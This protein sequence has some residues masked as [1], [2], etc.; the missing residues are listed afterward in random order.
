M[1]LY[2]RFPKEIEKE[3]KNLDKL[4][5]NK[6]EEIVNKIPDTLLTNKHKEY[7][8]IFIKE[9]KRLLQNILK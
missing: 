2:K 6:I 9:R 4:T 8:I 1:E 3:I 5:D 7:I